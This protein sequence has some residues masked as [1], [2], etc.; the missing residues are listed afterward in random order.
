[1][2]NFRLSVVYPV[3][4]YYLQ[5]TAFLLLK[6]SKIDPSRRQYILNAWDKITT[7][8][9]LHSAAVYSSSW[10]GDS[11]TTPGPCMVGGGGSIFYFFPI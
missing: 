10:A 5:R 1:M 3:S 7:P 4:T 9:P 11:F 2:L 6:K 8:G